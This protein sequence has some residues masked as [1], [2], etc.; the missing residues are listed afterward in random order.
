MIT[1]KQQGY[2]TITC[3]FDTK[4]RLNVIKI[5]TNKASLDEVLRDLIRRAKQ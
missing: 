2:T 5:K 1:T 3:S 4:D